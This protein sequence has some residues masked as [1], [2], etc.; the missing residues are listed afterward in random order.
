M[1][2]DEILASRSALKRFSRDFNVPVATY[3]GAYFEDQLETLALHAPYYKTLF[4]EFVN[5]LSE[6]VSIESYFE[7]YNSIK[8]NVITYIINQPEFKVFINSEI[9]APK[10]FPK[11]TLYK[12]TNS[13][14]DFISIDLRKANFTI[15]ERYCPNL[16]FGKSWEEFLKSFGASDYLVKSKYVRQVIFGACGPSKQIAAQTKLMTEIACKLQLQGYEIYSITT[17]EILIQVD[18]AEPINVNDIIFYISNELNYISDKLKIEYFTLK[19]NCCGYEKYVIAGTDVANMSVIF[20]SIPSDV[21]CQVVKY[22]YHKPI[23]DSD[24]VFDY[25]NRL[26]RFI[27]PIANP[28][29]DDYLGG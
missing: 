21:Y 22:F 20:K 25:N 16:F 5:E 1:T 2:R 24:L 4:E 10:I 26:A 9:K 29:T 3:D 15:L 27:S 11:E 13:G 23:A 17:D 19:A 28:F 12:P 14:F 18:P 6:F 8:D 7:H